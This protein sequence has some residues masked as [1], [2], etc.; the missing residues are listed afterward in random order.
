M[1]VCR[2]LGLPETTPRGVVVAELRSLATALLPGPLDEFA[3]WLATG[4]VTVVNVMAPE[5]VVLGDL[6]TA[7]PPA[8]VDHVRAVVHERSLVSRAV[9]GT[10]IVTS[11]LGR[12]AKVVGAAELAF[13]PVLGGV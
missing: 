2:A 3:D 9:G 6:F 7:L 8:I 5:L 4:L 10:R 1:A 12:D 13:E 11:P